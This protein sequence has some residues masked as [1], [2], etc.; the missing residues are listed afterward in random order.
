MTV[1]NDFFGREL[2]VGDKVVFMTPSVGRHHYRSFE[3][4]TISRFTN[5][6]VC[7]KLDNSETVIGTD[8]FKQLPQ[9][10]IMLERVCS[11]QQ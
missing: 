6:M 9:Q 7:I 8:E 4:G 5:K 10:V 1:F 3:V 2:C 11:T